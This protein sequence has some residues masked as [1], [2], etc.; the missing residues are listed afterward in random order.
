MARRCGCG[1]R[2][3]SS[4]ALGGLEGDVGGSDGAT[5]SLLLLLE[6]LRGRLNRDAETKLRGLLWIL[7]LARKKPG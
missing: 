1:V 6:L 2:S 5:S 3:P 4:G 7:E